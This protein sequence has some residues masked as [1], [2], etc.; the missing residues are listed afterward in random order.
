V[1]RYV[2]KYVVSPPIAVR[3]IDRYDGERVTYHYRSHRTERVEHETVEVDTF[4]G[5]MVQHT[6]PK[7]FKRI[8][9]YG[10]QATKT[11]AKVKVVIQAALAKVE[12]VVKGAV[13]IIARLTYRQRYA[14]STGRDPL[15]C[16]HCRGEMGVWRIWHPTYG[17]IYD[18]VR[19]IKR[20]TYASTAQRAGP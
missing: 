10:V 2:A 20:G 16:P 13:K 9:Y 1:A 5:R 7:G 4:I 12:G 14:Q 18:E 11:F 15:S 8:R 17:V 3:R 6:L 19:V